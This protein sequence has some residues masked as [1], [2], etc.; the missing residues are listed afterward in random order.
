MKENILFGLVWIFSSTLPANLHLRQIPFLADVLIK[1][2]GAGGSAEMVT[3]TVPTVPAQHC[4]TDNVK[5]NF[6]ACVQAKWAF[7][8]LHAFMNWKQVCGLV[9]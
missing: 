4:E 8:K 9:N 7:L 5:Q 1:D 2:C 6:L 3:N